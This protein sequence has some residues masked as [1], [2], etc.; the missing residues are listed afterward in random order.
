MEPANASERAVSTFVFSGM[1][2]ANALWKLSAAPQ[3]EMEETYVLNPH[4]SF[5]RVFTLTT[6]THRQQSQG[7]IHRQN[8]F[9]T[10]R[11][12]GGQ[13]ESS[14][15]SFIT[16]IAIGI[17]TLLQVHHQTRKGS[18]FASSFST[19]SNNPSINEDHVKAK[20]FQ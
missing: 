17:G 15:Q 13:G 2:P 16:C 10:A 18:C 12:C 3:E 6:F 9:E 14:S 11:T 4:H 20:R 1:E 19:I 8:H 7:H 5:N